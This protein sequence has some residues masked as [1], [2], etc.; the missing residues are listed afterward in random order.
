DA[1][2]KRGPVEQALI[3]V[4]VT[5]PENLIEVGRV[6]RSFDPCFTCAVHALQV[7]NAKPIFI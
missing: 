3:G 6:V 5:D 2:G 1:E 7:P 4:P